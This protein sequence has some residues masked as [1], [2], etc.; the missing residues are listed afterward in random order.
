MLSEKN[1]SY[2]Q[3]PLPSTTK[4]S[5]SIH[6]LDW[7][8]KKWLKRNFKQPIFQSGKRGRLTPQTSSQY[9]TYAAW[10]QYRK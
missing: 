5:T 2:N 6:S 3:Q 1:I 4:L 10:K 8:Q 9:G 7:K